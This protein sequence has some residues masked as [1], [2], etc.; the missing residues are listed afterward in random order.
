MLQGVHGQTIVFTKYQQARSLLLAE[1]G[2]SIG[3]SS[4]FGGRD[5]KLQGTKPRR[6]RMRVTDL[7]E[8]GK[9]ITC[10]LD[11]HDAE[12]SVAPLMRVE[13]SFVPDGANTRI[14]LRGAAVR[15]LTAASSMQAAAS[16]TLA[17]EYARGLL[18]QVAKAIE[19]RS[20]NGDPSSRQRTT[21]KPVLHKGG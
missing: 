4:E 8:R 1:G 11:L 18:D 9:T 20:A 16:R 12:R 2:P 14:S 17:N 10:Q 3:T 21:R 5:V 13:L 6:V 19:K 15:D 7:R